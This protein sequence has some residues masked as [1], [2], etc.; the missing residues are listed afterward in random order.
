MKQQHL[1][2][3]LEQHIALVVDAAVHNGHLGLFG[4]AADQMNA[5]NQ[6]FSTHPRASY[7]ARCTSVRQC[8]RSVAHCCAVDEHNATKGAGDVIFAPLSKEGQKIV[9]R[10][11]LTRYDLTK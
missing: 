3:D 10:Y 4:A 8:I 11:W 6:H 5:A 1:L 7:S 2:E 9:T